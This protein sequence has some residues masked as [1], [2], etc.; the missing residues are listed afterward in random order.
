MHEVKSRVVEV[1]IVRLT[2][3]GE[4]LGYFSLENG[5]TRSV[6]VPFTLPGERVRAEL[7]GKRSGH[8][9]S[10]LLENLSES[11]HR[12][13]PKCIHF[14][15]CGGCVFQHVAYQDQVEEK[16][17]RILKLFDGLLDQVHFDPPMPAP[18][19]WHY[20]NKMEFSFSQDKKGEKYLGLMMKAGSGRVFHLHEC[21]L[22]SSWFAE[23]V[24]IARKWWDSSDIPAFNPRNGEG[25]LRTLTAREGK[26]TGDRLINLTVSNHAEKGFNRKQ[27]QHLIEAIQLNLHQEKGTLSFFITIHQAKKGQ[28]TQFFEMHLLGPQ[29]YREQ[30]FVNGKEYVFQISPR[31]FFQ[32]NPLQAAKIYEEVARLGKIQSQSVVYDLY[33]G[34]G[35]MGITLAHL[36]KE[37]VGIELSSESV[38]DAKENVKLNSIENVTFYQGDVAEVLQLIV[39]KKLHPSPDVVLVDPPR[40]G[41]GDAAILQIAKLNPPKIVYVSCNPAT[42]AVDVKALFAHGYILTLLKPIDQ[43]PHTLHVETIAVLEKR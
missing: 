39:E 6:V 18:K 1:D 15:T 7:R 42:Q 28:P 14:T 8:F 23:L 21:H 31:A 40:A 17:E 35:T 26:R 22:T 13:A 3:K 11:S 38:L 29:T 27:V 41:L 30:L 16:K 24:V 32:P 34:T 12:I 25:V 33:C 9:R 43:F 36:A 4:G 5:E 2:N 10:I 37:V 19:E 20:R